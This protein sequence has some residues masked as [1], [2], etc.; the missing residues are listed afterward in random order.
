MV[1]EEMTKKGEF[2]I[3]GHELTIM[4]DIQSQIYT[5]RGVQVMLDL[6]LATLY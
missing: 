5:T 2:V 6:D 1:G 3:T 4:R